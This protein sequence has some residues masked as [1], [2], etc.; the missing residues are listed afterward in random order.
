MSNVNISNLIVRL[1]GQL[2]SEEDWKNH[3]PPINFELWRGIPFTNE[4]IEST[5]LRDRL[6]LSLLYSAG[7]KHTLTLL[8]QESLNILREELE[9]DWRDIVAEADRLARERFKETKEIRDMS[10]R[11]IEIGMSVEEVSNISGLSKDDVIR[12]AN[13]TME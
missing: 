1:D 6:L 7:I 9:E 2:L 11:M 8:P 13:K 4:S 10:R 12:I 3:T 5:I